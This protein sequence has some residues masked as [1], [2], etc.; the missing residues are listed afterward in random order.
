MTI[1]FMMLFG[2][3]GQSEMN[4]YGNNSKQIR[5]EERE[6]KWIPATIL[7]DISLVVIFLFA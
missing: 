6:R 1:L 5:I 7:I 3:W 4:W 2:R